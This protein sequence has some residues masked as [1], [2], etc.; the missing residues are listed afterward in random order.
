MD[1]PPAPKKLHRPRPSRTSSNVDKSSALPPSQRNPTALR[2]ALPTLH[3]PTRHH[4]HHQHPEKHRRHAEKYPL[5]HA[6]VHSPA[7]VP[8]ALVE[9]FT[10][11]RTNLKVGPTS[12]Q[13]TTRVDET[14][15]APIQLP[16]RPVQPLDVAKERHRRVR[17]EEE[18]RSTLDCLSSL[19]SDSTRRVDLL[20]M[21]IKEKLATFQ[22]TIQRMQELSVETNKMRVDF[23]GEAKQVEMTYERQVETFHGFDQQKQHAESL[24][25]RI[26]KSIEKSEGLQE[27]LQAARNKVSEWEKREDEWQARTSMKL[28]ICWACF[29]AILGLVVVGLVVHAILTRT[30]TPRIAVPTPKNTP[31]LQSLWEELHIARPSI[32]PRSWAATSDIT[33]PNDTRLQVLDEL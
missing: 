14:G 5:A 1:H 29:G 32:R 23:E 15:A 13:S 28:R 10:S 4:H 16:P 17:R 9:K 31:S 7:N 22:S 6:A 18:L 30:R 24:R 21:S 33:L 26:E 3:L 20:F 19:A 25:E 11:S 12:L 27:R 2:Q 8:S